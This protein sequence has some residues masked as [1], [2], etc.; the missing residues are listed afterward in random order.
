[1][2]MVVN[3]EVLTIIEN[4]YGLTSSW[5]IWAP[6]SNGDWSTKDSVGDLTP[7]HDIRR[8]QEQVNDEYIFVGLNPA[9]HNHSDAAK[10]VWGNF[11]SDDLRRAQDYK[12]RYALRDTPYW[13]SFMT[14]VYSG[15]VDTNANSAVKKATSTDTEQSIK[16]ILRIRDLLGGK[17]TVVAMGSKAYA[18]LKKTLPSDVCL[19][20]ITHY[21]SYVG[22]EKYRE[23]VLH[24][25]G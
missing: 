8:L 25:L 13:G 23:D 11:H 24:Q 2:N 18:I 1:M 17:S 6:P 10:Q 22:L 20:R 7:L 21:S 15:I 3:T 4:E 16:D 12:L 5:A 9:E 19:K 14:D